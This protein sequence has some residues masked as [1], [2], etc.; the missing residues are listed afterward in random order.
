VR[1]LLFNPNRSLHITERMAASARAELRAPHQLLAVTGS[2][3]PQVVHDAATLQQADAEALRAVPALMQA[4][5]ALLLAISLDGV[6]D[7][8]R[9]RLAPQPARG[10]TEAA[11]AAAAALGGRV[12]LLTLGPGLL[13]LYQARLAALLPAERIAGLQ[14]P[15]LPQAFA[16]DAD[17]AALLPTL[18]AAC[19][20]LQQQGADSIVLAGAVL[21]GY[22]EALQAALGLPVLDGMRCAVRQLQDEGTP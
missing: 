18:L 3:G 16:P 4:A 11:V 2:A 5:D 1:I 12:G 10:L 6:I 9:P 19:R 8:L 22:D 14:A 17:P 15:E 21:C 13:P 7:Q 20:R